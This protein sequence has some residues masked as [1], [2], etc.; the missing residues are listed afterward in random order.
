MAGMPTAPT[1]LAISH[2]T[3]SPE[4]QRAVA[5]LMDAVARR[6]PHVPVQL[7]HVD[8]QQPD[9]TASLAAIPSGQ[10]VIIVPLLLSAGYHVHVDLVEQTATDDRVTIVPA[11]GPDHRLVDVLV[12]RLL[13]LE[14]HAQ[15]AVVLAVAGSSDERANEDC[16]QMAR[17]LSD[18]VERHVTVGF[19]AAAEPR[20]PDAIAAASVG[21]SRV[22][23]STYLLAPGYFQERARSLA[24][25]A[26]VTAP[27]LDPAGAP[28]RLVE[29]V[30]ARYQSAIVSG[31]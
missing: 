21:V 30:L 13:P 20:L 11:L 31:P 26:A 12:D 3:A 24:G 23:V 4:G 15:D 5:A 2:G 9:V 14:P 16:R 1:L 22:V 8:V 28:D 25:G 29:L 7:G 17:L 6:V 27:L 10:P 19:L 18:R